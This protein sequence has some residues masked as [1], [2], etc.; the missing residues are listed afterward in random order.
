MFSVL[1]YDGAVLLEPPKKIV[2]GFYVCDKQFRLDPIL[3]MF[4]DEICFGIA[5]ITG[6]MYAFYK[7][8]K[9]GNHIEH[10]KIL[11]ATVDLQKKHKKGGSSSARF[12]RLHDEKEDAY[13]KKLGELVIKCFMNETNTK[14]LVEKLIIAGPSEK[15]NMLAQDELVKKYFNTK[16]TLLNTPNLND[17]TIIE[18]INST[19]QLFDSDND[20]QD[21][22]AIDNVL[23]L[24]ALGD[25]KLV[26]GIQEICV[27]LVNNSLQE[28]ITNPDNM[29]LLTIKKNNKCNI[30]VIDNF[31]LKKLGLD[32]VGVKWF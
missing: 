3:E 30:R 20:N 28:L 2:N 1:N 31:K 15:K 10:K 27:C 12:G 4:N 29:Q 18:T 7:I 17:Q 32:I 6:K 24:M 22:I 8:S 16:I 23:N 9:S 21:N 19:R 26:F 5:F 13:I 14:H 11:S 25:D